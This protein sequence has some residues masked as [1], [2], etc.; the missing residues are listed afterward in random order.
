MFTIFDIINIL[1]RQVATLVD[2]VQDA[3]HY[4]VLWDGR[5][6]RGLDVASGIYFYRLEAEDFAQT[7]KMTLLK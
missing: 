3:G 7:R 1:G 4:E 5:D 6:S 2:D